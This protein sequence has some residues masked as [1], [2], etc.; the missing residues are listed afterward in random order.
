MPKLNFF[1]APTV[2]ESGIQ[3]ANAMPRGRVWGK[4]DLP[5]TNIY[6]LIRSLAASFNLVQQQIELLA[7]EY[8]INLSVDLLPDWETSVG[9]PDECLMELD[10]LEQRRNAV[11][12]RLRG[13][14]VVTKEEFEALG[15]E[16]IDQEITVTDGW[17]FD[18]ANNY[19]DTYSRF[20]MYVQFPFA[21]TGFPYAFPLPFGRFRNDLITCVFDKIK[22]ANTII[23]YL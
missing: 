15:L 23:I 10:T 7:Q 13:V 9:I 20:K 4:K 19:P 17:S 3:L 14:P 16:L 2:E 18:T 12:S 1:D 8:Q 5:D 6:K 11:I 22:P 21:P